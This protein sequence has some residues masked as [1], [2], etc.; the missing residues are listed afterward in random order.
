MA[1]SY[2]RFLFVGNISKIPTIKMTGSGKPMGRLGVA[3]NQAWRAKDGEYKKQSYF[4]EVTVWDEFLVKRTAKFKVGD[5]VLIEGDINPGKYENTSGQTVYVMNFVATSIISMALSKREAD[6]S[7]LPKPQLEE[8]EFAPDFVT[9][10]EP[11][12]TNLAPPQPK[13]K[14]TVTVDAVEELFNDID[15]PFD[16]Q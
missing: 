10:H 6:E 5:M 13:K 14:K 16:Q 8:D 2:H 12:M 3:V 4:F 15:L 7:I 11:A 9:G 1:F